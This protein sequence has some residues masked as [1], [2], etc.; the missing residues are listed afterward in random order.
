MKKVSA[1]LI[2]FFGLVVV[3]IFAGC[4]VSGTFVIDLD[5]DNT[6]ISTE[7]EFQ[8]F[9]VDLTD[10]E[11]WEDHRDK[12]EFID[13][14]GFQ[15][16]VENNGASNAG[17]EFYITRDFSVDIDNAQEV[18]DNAIRVLSGL[19]LVSDDNYIDWPTSLG[20]VENLD[21]LKSIVLTENDEDTDDGFVIYALTTTLPFEITIDSATVIVTVTAS[22]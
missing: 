13:N 18:R 17:V 8:Y 1:K 7:S 15:L 2:P 21:S 20:L 9:I 16:W 4:L 19:T 6:D 3:T 11:D 12:I 10:N 5:I 14:I 22:E